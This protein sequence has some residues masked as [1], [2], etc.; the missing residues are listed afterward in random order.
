MSF[1]TK[2]VPEEGRLLC[3][4]EHHL[5]PRDKEM[6]DEKTEIGLAGK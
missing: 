4:K 6:T 1:G 5:S 2:G 3:R